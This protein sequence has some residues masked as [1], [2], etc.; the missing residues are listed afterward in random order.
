[1]PLHA[2]GTAP[3][4]PSPRPRR[5]LWATSLFPPA[6]RTASA[7][8]RVAGGYALGGVLLAAVALLRQ[9]GVPATNTVWAEDAKI[10][11]A[12]ALNMPFGRALFH[13]YDGYAQLVPRLLAEVA[14]GAPPARAAEVFAL[15]GAIGFAV[16]ACLVFHMSRGHI[17]APAVRAVL[18]A[19]MAL[20]PVAT[21]ELLDNLV[22]LPWWLFFAAFWA[23]LWRPQTAAGRVA[24]A[25]VCFLATASEPLVA[26]FVPLA[27]VR[28]L[29]LRARREHAAAAGMVLGLV[30]EGIARLASGGKPFTPAALSGIGQDYAERVGLSMLG[31]VRASGWLI[32]RRPTTAIT[33]G[34]LLA[35]AVVVAGL[36]ARRREARCFTVAAAAFSAVCFVVPVWLRGVSAVL[37]TSP[38]AEASRYQVVP[39]LLLISIALV[40]AGDLARPTAEGA[41]GPAHAGPVPS[42]AARRSRRGAL[43]V[44]VA[45]AALLLPAW[46]A[47][48]RDAN[49][50]S[51]GPVW[52]AQV[53]RATA[54]C[55]DSHAATATLRID[56]PGWKAV[57]VCRALAA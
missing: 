41:T 15:A 17:R 38:L 42:A 20:L 47:D 16:T 30:Y 46:V 56:P 24:A 7:P 35:G 3:D 32:G 51:A 10:F 31:G 13:T 11:Y 25:T 34:A 53:A 36:R 21:S 8:A 50:R 14:R 18:V 1:M 33:V 40:A 22:N 29:A 44:P 43:A 48:F 9:S 23:F 54:H 26:L 57:L 45:C 4:R 27:V 37:S 6:G 55:R 49:P 28:A 19:S 39:L 52:P 12:Q 5:R 2:A